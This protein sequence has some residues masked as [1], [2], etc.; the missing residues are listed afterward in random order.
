MA[1]VKLQVPADRSGEFHCNAPQQS[2]TVYRNLV[3]GSVIDVDTRDVPAM[4][5]NGFAYAVITVS[6]LS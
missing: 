5:Q 3:P 1:T 6:A 2:G 4:L